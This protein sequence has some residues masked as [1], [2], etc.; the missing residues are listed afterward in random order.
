MRP[1]WWL[2]RGAED[3]SVDR[4]VEAFADGLATGLTTLEQYWAGLGKGRPTALLAALVK[5]ELWRGFE[6]GC[7]PRVLDYLAR[8]P[9]L[10]EDAERVVSLVYEEFCLLQ[11]VGANPDSREFCRDYDPWRDS[12]ASQLAY[13]R[14]LSRAVGLEVNEVSFPEPGELFER[15]R[16]RSL[17]GKGGV[18]R[19]YLATEEGLGERQVVIK[20]S[21]SFGQ[22]PSIL[23][24]LDHRNIVPILTVAESIS[25]LRGICMPYRPGRTL[26]ELIARLGP[27]PPPRSAKAFFEALRVLGRPAEVP[28]E[29]LDSGW[30]EFPVDRT[31]PEAVAWIGQRLTRALAY[32]HK[33]GVFH[34]DI[35]PANILLAFN[36]GP[37]LLDFNLAKEP[38]NPEGASVA[39]RGGTL[40]YMAPEQLAAF[41]DPSAWSAV[42]EAADILFSRIG[43]PRVADWA[44]ARAADLPRVA[45]PRDPIPP[46]PASH[47]VPSQSERSTRRSPRLWSRF[48]RN[49]SPSGPRTAMPMQGKL[50]ADL[51][52]FLDRR[53]LIVA[54][55][56]S[57]FE[58]GFNCFYRNRKLV[59]ATA[60]VAV[61]FAPVLNFVRG[62]ESGVAAL[63]KADLLYKSGRKGDLDRARV[64]YE[65]LHRDHP[66]TTRPSLGLAMSLIK[67]DANDKTPINDLLKEAAENPDAEEA[68][69]ERL[70]MD[71]ASGP[72]LRSLG[73]VLMARNSYDRAREMLER[74]L[75][76]DPD[77][78]SGI[79]LI[80][81]LEKKV[82]RDEIAA[83]YYQRAIG[84]ALRDKAK[85]AVVYQLRKHWL[86]TLVRVIDR[87]LGTGGPGEDRPGATRWL[88]LLK[89]GLV[90]FDDDQRDVADVVNHDDHFLAREYLW[91]CSASIE[92]AL[93]SDAE[94]KTRSMTLFRMADERFAAARATFSKHQPTPEWIAMVSNQLKTLE[95]RR[96]ATIGQ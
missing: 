57:R 31:F 91:G 65:T 76:V 10:A 75:R 30:A 82:G 2:S 71:P 14:E 19:V 6:T 18:A 35:K 37:Q 66:K 17:L 80:A 45:S 88:G 29:E 96:L 1:R 3:R 58:R 25:G 94:D 64:M 73:H 42:G 89:A 27:G 48:S 33:K 95:K 34:R 78:I 23:A 49:A 72:L 50:E 39:Q 16:L 13:H 87:A 62:D 36:E 24:M 69:E 86:F 8:F 61:T 70:T 90:T 41:L 15:Y 81:N 68:L 12:L 56:P 40:P 32:L 43:A 55:N 9:E 85:P 77:S 52:R 92:A 38:N 83:G 46:G 7:R 67:L 60:L 22:E 26:E 28:G 5:V 44:W 4:A 51:R 54:P 21:A 11:E 84:L 93:L 47:P 63:A 59:L 79:A 74:A 20:V 53:P